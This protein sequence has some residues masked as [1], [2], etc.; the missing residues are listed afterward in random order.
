M[1]KRGKK[2][3]EKK[4]KRKKREKRKRIGRKEKRERRKEKK[5]QEPNPVYKHWQLSGL[6]FILNLMGN[7]RQCIC[8]LFQVSLEGPVY[9]RSNLWQTAHCSSS[10]K[11]KL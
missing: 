9:Q 11:L 6:L 7:E 2:N 5:K 10:N 3:G 1:E 8:K 4:K